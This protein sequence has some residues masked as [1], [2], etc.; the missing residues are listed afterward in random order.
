MTVL[1]FA[2]GGVLNLNT[3][4]LRKKLTNTHFDGDWN[5]LCNEGTILIPRVGNG[6]ILGPGYGLVA[7]REGYHSGSFC[8]AWFQGTTVVIINQTSTDYSNTSTPAADKIGLAWN[9]GA[10][11]WYVYSNYSTGNTQSFFQ[12]YGIQTS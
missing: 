8:L 1:A 5:I 12:V 10:G 11:A 3:P 9:A 7:I 2:Q 6:Q 4:V